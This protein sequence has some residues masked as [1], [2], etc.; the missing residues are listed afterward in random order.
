MELLYFLEGL[1]NPPLDFIMSLITRFGDETLFMAMALVMFWCV[2]KFRGYLVLCVGFMGTLINQFLKYKEGSAG[3][4]MTA[5][6][7][8]LKKSMTVEDAL[9]YIRTTGIDKETIYTCYV[10][11]NHRKLEG[12]VTLK[13]LI[14]AEPDEVVSEIMSTNIISATTDEEQ[15]AVAL[16]FDKY[17]LIAL[18]VVDTENR[19]VGIITVDDVIDVLQEETT[20]DIEKMVKTGVK[21]I[22]NS[23]AHDPLS[24]GKNH[25]AFNLIEKYK[26]PLEQVVNLNEI[27]K[28][29]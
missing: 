28:F 10:M 8:A 27:P 2:D 12:V 24:V 26:I 20:E 3:S 18:P 29:N 4:I 5:E 1:R 21:F 6:Y 15:E 23:D 25:R 9:K 7:V 17:D 19:L 14:M 16:T 11:N 13:E 22:I